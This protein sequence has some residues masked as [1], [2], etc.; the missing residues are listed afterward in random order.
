MIANSLSA[1]SEFFDSMLNLIPVT[2]YY[3]NQ[4]AHDSK[5]QHNKKSETGALTHKGK[6]KKRGA[7]EE[8]SGLS[9]KAKTEE[10]QSRFDPANYKT[11]LDVQKASFQSAPKKKATPQPKPATKTTKTPQDKNV[12][13][14]SAPAA[15]MSI[16]DLRKRLHDRISSLRNGR[17][18]EP[19]KEQ[20]QQ[21]Q[22]VKKQVKKPK[23]KK[24]QKQQET[25]ADPAP[26]DPHQD[27]PALVDEEKQ[28]SLDFTFGALKKPEE[29]STGFKRKRETN[30][31]ALAKLQQYNEFISTLEQDD[32]ER[33]KEIKTQK[34]FKAAIARSQGVAV[35]DDARLLKNAIRR[36]KAKTKK[37]QKEWKTRTKE[38]AQHAKERQV[39]RVQNLK[40]RNAGKKKKKGRAGFEGT[41]SAAF[42]N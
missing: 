26:V 22:S 10:K 39:K 24:Q 12:E 15:A 30:A 14:T 3:P 7:T 8:G 19:T 20:K 17:K 41:G 28:M 11:V 1:D 9:K 27:Q 2:Y 36:Q 33:A 16:D 23:E 40:E 32:P 37:S 38:V 31:K 35:K 5:F 4:A 29:K 18:P 25:P 6:G 21:R 34:A 13:Q 42:L